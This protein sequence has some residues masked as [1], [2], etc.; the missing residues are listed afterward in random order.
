MKPSVV[1]ILCLIAALGTYAFAITRS[2]A[3]PEQEEQSL[4]YSKFG[5]GPSILLLHSSSTSELDWAE[6]ASEL[7]NRFE[8]T[9]V[10]ISEYLNDSK[11]VQ[12]LRSALRALDIDDRRI[13]GS[14]QAEQLALR[15]ALSYP[16][17][18]DSFTLP[19]NSE[20]LQ[21]LA[22]IFNSTQCTNS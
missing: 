19:H 17:Q 15:Y 18:S 4:Q 9:L 20:D 2:H 3:N 11:G 13:A 7:A 21:I 14:A 16:S 5:H 12:R 6:A 22:D 1:K 8:V 10:D